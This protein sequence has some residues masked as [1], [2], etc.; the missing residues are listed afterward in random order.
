MPPSICIRRAEL[1]DV[2]AV[3]LLITAQID[4]IKTYYGVIDI[5]KII[6]TS[7]FSVVATATATATATIAAT[8]TN[9][10]VHLL[11][12]DIV[13]FAALS[14][15]PHALVDDDH[16]N[17]DGAT[18]TKTSQGPW[19]VWFKSRFD[20][21]Q[22]QVW[23]AKFLSVFTSTPTHSCEFLDMFL[24]AAFQHIPL[25]S[26]ILFVIPEN[27]QLYAP[28]FYPILKRGTE[29]VL[30]AEYTQLGHINPETPNYFE[31]VPSKLAKNYG[32]FVCSKASILPAFIVRKAMVEDWDDLLP[33]L[34]NQHV[35]N[36]YQEQ[37][38]LS[39][40]LDPKVPGEL[41]LV[42]AEAGKP[43]GF[44]KCSRNVDVQFLLTHFEV[45]GSLLQHLSNSTNV[46]CISIFALAH[47]ASHYCIDILKHSFASYGDCEYA[48]LVVPPKANG[49][50]LLSYFE[51]IPTRPH[52]DADFCL[53]VTSRTGLLSNLKVRLAVDQDDQPR[54]KQFT[55]KK[56]F[57]KPGLLR[58]ASSK[59]ILP[60]SLSPSDLT[61][62]NSTVTMIAECN[63]KIVAVATFEPAQNSRAL[64]DQFH[65]DAFCDVSV[66]RASYEMR[67]VVL[68][69][70][71]LDEIFTVRARWMF[72]E[73][74]RTSGISV[75]FNFTDVET[76]QD[77]YVGRILKEEMV[78]VPRRRQIVFPRNLRDGKSVPS[79]IR[80]NLQVITMP[81]VHEPQVTVN[82]RIVILG[83]SDVALAL[84]SKLV[85]NGYLAY[86]QVY[87]ISTCGIQVRGPND[88]LV[89]H[90]GYSHLLIGSVAIP[91]NHQR[92][93]GIHRSNAQTCAAE[94]RKY[95]SD[96]QAFAT[97]E[98]LLRRGTT[99]KMAC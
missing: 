73:F 90:R 19:D 55:S 56:N 2:P 76:I 54:I 17:I 46:F 65:V 39:D 79:P 12:Q 68:K 21:K 15:G 33:I 43:V 53:H 41:S 37:Y 16:G 6:D 11:N 45:Y 86:T 44:I 97:S 61:L 74:M 69:H 22:V 42:A 47:S 92:G 77:T 85:Y 88:G 7:P 94:Q 67:P 98:G 83:C 9:T 8:P 10:H 34:M 40:I 4:H 31:P 91:H 71:V 60:T 95:G 57:V 1:S 28:L 5:A 64:V 52:S 48:V 59:S 3:K 23:N 72:E 75:L 70:F 84:I 62:L 13:G 49:F 35:I 51:R 32:C 30:A 87:L 82:R 38:A 63:S 50:Q 93:T 20:I 89:N 27:A 81:L 36:S 80:D 25:L 14:N 26:Y 18:A 29:N 96:F 99:G 78:P 66:Q 58:S 24:P